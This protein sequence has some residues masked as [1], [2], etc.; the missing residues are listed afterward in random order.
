MAGEETLLDVRSEATVEGLNKF[1]D[2]GVSGA[3]YPL[4]VVFLWA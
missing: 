3:A 2:V 4:L 1:E